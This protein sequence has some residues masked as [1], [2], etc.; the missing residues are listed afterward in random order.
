MLQNETIKTLSRKNSCV[1]R[2]TNSFKAGPGRGGG[3]VGPRL[4]QMRQQIQQLNRFLIILHFEMKI[5]FKKGQYENTVSRSVLWTPPRS[6]VEPKPRPTFGAPCRSALGTR[7]CGPRLGKLPSSYKILITGPKFKT[8]CT[9]QKRNASRP[10]MC[11]VLV[12]RRRVAGSW[13]SPSRSD[14]VGQGG[15]PRGPR[16]PAGQAP[17]SRLPRLP[18]PWQPLVLTA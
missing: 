8:T 2:G 16:P 17:P 3:E 6:D 10:L 18:A 4:A 5:N 13:F 11:T 15:L 12:Q 1:P 14:E 7:L 9:N